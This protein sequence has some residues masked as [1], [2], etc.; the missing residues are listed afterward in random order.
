MKEQ[1]AIILLKELSAKQ[2][3]QPISVK[4]EQRKP[5]RFQLK[6]KGSYDFELIQAYANFKD[7]SIK[8]NGNNEIVIFKP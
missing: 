2:L 6:I 8:Q 1:E 4:I 7:M 3:V 5:D